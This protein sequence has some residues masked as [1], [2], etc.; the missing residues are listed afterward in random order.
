MFHASNL[1]AA[2]RAEVPQDDLPRDVRYG[3][4]SPIHDD[5]IA[6]ICA[7]LRATSFQFRWTSRDVLVVDNMRMAHGRRP[8]AGPRSVV[9][10]MTGTHRCTESTDDC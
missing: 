3:D 5:D 2:M 7:V 10:A 6:Q 9:V 8:F 4:G 1:P